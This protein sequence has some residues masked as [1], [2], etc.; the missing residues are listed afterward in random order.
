MSAE[1]KTQLY[2]RPFRYL[3]QWI[4]SRF[5]NTRDRELDRLVEDIWTGKDR[6][7]SDL[8]SLR[9]YH[10][11][12][13]DRKTSHYVD[14]KTWSDL[15]MDDVF[16]E[17]NRTSSAIG[18]QY[19]YHNLHKYETDRELLGVRRQEYD[20]LTKNIEVREKIQKS[21]IR[22]RSTSNCF[23]AR[24]LFGAL[25]HRPGYYLLFPALSIL[26][27]ALIIISFKFNVFFLAALGLAIVNICIYQYFTPRIAG[28]MPDMSSLSTLLRV[29]ESIAEYDVDKALPEIQALKKHGSLAKTINK[30]IGWLV[31]DTSRTVDFTAMVIDYLDHFFL[32][33]LIAFLRSTDELVRHQKALI[34]MYENIG[35][36]DTAVA[37]AGYLNT[38]QYHCTAELS[39]D[40]QIAVSDIYHPLLKDPVSNSL[41][42]SG[43]SCLITGSNM[44]G[45]TTFIKTIGVNTI[46]ARS[47]NICLARKAL[48]PEAIVKTSIKRQDSLDDNKSYYFMEIEDILSFI[49]ASETDDRYLF[50]IDEIFRG[51]NTIERLSS[52][53]SVLEHLCGKDICLVTTHDIELQDLLDDQYEMYHFMEQVEGEKYFF[54]YKIKHGPCHSGNAIRLLELM[55]YPERIVKNAFSLADELAMKLSD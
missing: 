27:L 45:K 43:K 3:G 54:D 9:I 41:S 8:D 22:L 15:N 29:V 20:Y 37:L 51:T 36:L 1:E 2:T 39:T 44:A 35:S 26:M 13:K 23:I 7:E 30:K 40:N 53:T 10:D 25:P 42:V 19:L 11:L 4:K 24:M 34:E 32:F 55:G 47:V 6:I 12:K 38:A 31:V 14:D 48:L 17:V 28:Y 49:K 16:S 5:A 46:L 50:L 18:S 52:A 21:L 33:N